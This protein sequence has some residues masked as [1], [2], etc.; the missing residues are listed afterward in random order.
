[1]N[2]KKNTENCMVCS[3]VL[4]YLQH[5]ENLTC[6]NCG[7]SVQGS[8]TCPRGHFICEDC[9]AGDLKSVILGLALATTSEDPA[10]IAELMM[11]R[12]YLP[13]LGCEHAYIAAGTLM[14]ALKNSP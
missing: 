9:H 2:E 1:M 3:S 14:A 7:K 10:A 12:P 6:T 5:A 4:D 8:S 11:G 13:M